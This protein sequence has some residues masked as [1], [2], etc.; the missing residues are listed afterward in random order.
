MFNTVTAEQ[1]A[2][3]AEQFDDVHVSSQNFGQDKD[4]SLLTAW[5]AERITD[6]GPMRAAVFV[7][8]KP[9][10]AISS[11]GF[12]VERLAQLRS[13]FETCPNLIQEVS[14]NATPPHPRWLSDGS[15]FFL[16]PLLHDGI[17][18]GVLCLH[19]TETR[20]QSL[21]R[22][23]WRSL[24]PI[25]ATAADAIVSVL[26]KEAAQQTRADALRAT[27]ARATVT[28]R[29][30]GNIAHDIRTPATVVRGYIR[31]LM[32]GRAGPLSPDQR[33]CLE[34]ALNGAT[35]L[36]ALGATVE[37][38]AHELPRLSAESL[39]LRDLWLE[40]RHTN[41]REALARAITINESIPSQRV[42]VTGDRAAITTLLEQLLAQALEK[43]E[44]NGEVRVDLS[45]KAGAATLEISLPLDDLARHMEE[46]APGALFFGLRKKAFIQ[47]GTLLC[48]RKQEANPQKESATITVSLPGGWA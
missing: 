21:L 4:L 13:R 40:A 36:G 23:H 24:E 19:S 25:C 2:S 7:L 22:K 27:D 42:P 35:K 47:G 31:M 41:R 39:D 12:P 5:I 20:C 28:T 11:D 6:I 26:E 10:R 44:R 1:P 32:D 45:G 46:N 29:L 3:S 43:A 16:L 37:E 18:E 15:I 33:D 48:W 38:A 30:L 34:L 17:L 9:L 14:R 8:G